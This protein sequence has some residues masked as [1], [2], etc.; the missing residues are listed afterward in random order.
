[1]ATVLLAEPSAPVASALRRFLE[2]V[3]H[4]VAWVGSAAEARRLLEDRPPGVLVASASLP[5]DG[6]ALCQELRQKGSRLPVLLVYPPDEEHAD[7]RAAE[8]G[9]EGCLVGPLKRG[10]VV[11]CVSLVLRL[12]EAGTRPVAPEAAAAA[13]AVAIPARPGGLPERRA[14]RTDLF[15]V[16]SSPDF[17]FL[18]R[19]LLMEVKR[20]RRY[21][22]PIS[23]LLVEV[24]RF[25]E[26]TLSLAPQAR[27]AL[28]AEALGLLT[29]GVRDIDVVVPFADSRFV[30]FL[31]HTPRSGARVVA[32]RLL[33][34]MHALK[35]LPGATASV[36]VA[37][38]EPPAGGTKA[39]TQGAGLSFGGLLKEAGD[40][41][42]RAQAGGGDS[43][44]VAQAGPGTQEG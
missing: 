35:A 20:S 16:S 38:S 19:L 12:A 28:L 39:L 37:V 11:T 25:T 8:A 14:S 10:T 34:R 17:D 27:T 33:E 42:R 43:V 15:A 26:H 40:A 1:M 41:L 7:T 13:S 36:G 18:K 22:Y 2:G 31:P 5:V 24:D 30:V 23:L 9:A 44:V 4:E 6:E 29:A 32:E 3:G 21:R